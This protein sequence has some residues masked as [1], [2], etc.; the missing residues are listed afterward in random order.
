[1][2][3]LVLEVMRPPSAMGMNKSGAQ[4][5]L[6]NS[7]PPLMTRSRA[8]GEKLLAAQWRN[9]AGAHQTKSQELAH[10]PLSLALFFL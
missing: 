5:L 6:Y 1:M 3:G 10:L 8:S 4:C 9:A 2:P 7:F